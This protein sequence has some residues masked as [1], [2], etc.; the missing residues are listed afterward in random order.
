MKVTLILSIKADKVMNK[1][2]L[3]NDQ[4]IQCCECGY[5]INLGRNLAQSLEHVQNVLSSAIN[6][7]QNKKCK[8]QSQDQHTHTRTPIYTHT[9]MHMYAYVYMYVYIIYDIFAN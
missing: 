4:Q 5:K 9:D 7:H 6:K 8:Y 3:F 2:I 1:A